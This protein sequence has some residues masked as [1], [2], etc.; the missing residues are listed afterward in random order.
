MTRDRWLGL[1]LLELMIVVAIAGILAAVAF[2]GYQE[3]IRKAK[4]TDAHDALLRVQL[5]QAKWR[6]NHVAYTADLSEDGLGVGATSAQGHYTLAVPSARVN[7]F[8]ASATAIG[9]QAND[10]RCAVITLEVAA[11]GE[12]RGPAGCW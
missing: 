7:G 9:M 12:T 1:T 3:Q 8:G 10:T 5:A 2:P 11:G 4:R 6:A